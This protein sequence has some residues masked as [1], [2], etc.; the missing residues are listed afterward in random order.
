[1]DSNRTA[2]RKWQ[3]FDC[4]ELQC[5]DNLSKRKSAELPI[6]NSAAYLLL[7]SPLEPSRMNVLVKSSFLAKTPRGIPP[8]HPAISTRL[9]NAVG[10]PRSLHTLQQGCVTLPRLYGQRRSEKVTKRTEGKQMRRN[11]GDGRRR[12]LS[13]IESNT[14]FKTCR[15]VVVRGIIK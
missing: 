10:S 11:N 13:Q 3:I 8:C 5:A 6:H 4:E 14:V 9:A 7:D 2:S 15:D 1:M 12:C